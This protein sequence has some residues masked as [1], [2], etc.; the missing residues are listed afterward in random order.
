MKTLKEIGLETPGH[1]KCEDTDFEDYLP[2][3]DKCWTPIRNC[4]ITLLEIGIGRGGS[5]KM[6]K[7]YFQNGCIFGADLEEH[8]LYKEDRINTILINQDSIES[9]K[10]LIPLGPFDIIIDDGGHQMHQ[11]INTLI[12][13]FDSVK[14][15]GYYI[16]ED[17]CTSYWPHFGGSYPVS[18]LTTVE[19]LKHLCDEVNKLYIGYANYG[20]AKNSREIPNFNVKNIKSISFHQGVIIMEKK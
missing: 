5:L 13:L 4:P 10:S 12:T 16:I 20:S 19:Y 18:Q 7:E 9:I 14:K 1:S 8:K 17:V 15:N 2:I 6:W 3:Y 11:Q